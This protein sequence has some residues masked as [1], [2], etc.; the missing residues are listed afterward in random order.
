MKHI[1]R[2][3]SFPIGLVLIAVGIIIVTVVHNVLNDEFEKAAVVIPNNGADEIVD[4]WIRF[5][6]NEKDPNNERIYKFYAYN[7][8]NPEDVLKGEL[9]KY[10]EV[11]PYNYKYVYERI[12]YEL[13]DDEERLK[14]QL[15]KRYYPLNQTQINGTRDPTTDTIYH[16]NLAYAAVLEQAGPL[17]ETAVAL[18]M[19]AAYV[20]QVLATLNSQVFVD[21]ALPMMTPLLYGQYLN[22]YIAQGKSPIDFCNDLLDESKK[23]SIPLSFYNFG[24]PPTGFAS[25]QCQNLFSATTGSIIDTNSY[26]GYLTG[27]IATTLAAAPFSFDSDSVAFVIQYWTLTKNNIV[28]MS[29]KKN[30]PECVTSTCTNNDLGLLQWA[31]ADGLANGKSVAELAP[32]L[33][34]ITP[35]E[36]G[37]NTG[38]SLSL[39]QTKVLASE[40]SQINLVTPTGMGTIITLLKTPQGQQQLVAAGFSAEQVGALGVYINAMLSNFSDAVMESKVFGKYAGGP[41]AKHTVHDMLFNAIDPLLALLKK[42][43]DP[44]HWKSSPLENIQTKEEAEKELHFDSI[45]TGVGDIGKVSA[46]I[47]FENATKLQYQTLIPVSGSF[48]EQLPPNYLFDDIEADVNVFTEEYARSLTFYKEFGGDFNGIPYY[49]YRVK[50][51]NWQVNQ[52]Y[53]QTI[54]F[55]MNLT[56]IKGGAPAFLSRPRMKGLAPGYFYKAGVEELINDQ[57]DLDVFADY[58]PRSGKAIHGRY[59]LQVNGYVPGI[60]GEKNPSYNRYSNM[61]SDVIHPMF[62]GV[63]VIAAT[64]DQVDI[65]TKAYKVDSVRYALT[66]ILIVIGG[67]LS[68]VSSG[69]FVLDIFEKKGYF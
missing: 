27:S 45:F 54:P 47:T 41:I 17:G 31:L 8:T 32:T 11:G 10:E 55:L 30:I 7:C 12:N 2:F 35:P 60:D 28:P 56:S 57:E 44:S 39:A 62:W 69:L 40:K 65:L 20:S 58:E 42:D 61:R 53:Y 52:D 46:P 23:G 43:E 51:E 14:F 18:G 49:R 1:G 36:F 9:P 25:A 5:I 67:F 6:G 3:V 37:I 64:D 13:Y 68:L 63:N 50:D 48:A 24:V 66:T 26:K 15:W 21:M 34:L 19:A 16:F 29:I 22:A 4:P 59:S 33:G 38:V